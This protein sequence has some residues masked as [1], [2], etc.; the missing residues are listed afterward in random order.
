MQ[1]N[2][3]KDYDLKER[4]PVLYNKA[5]IYI[6]TALLSTFFGAIFYSMNLHQF[7]KK[8]Q[9]PP[10]LIFGV[11]WNGLCIYI[12]RALK[13]TNST[14]VLFLPNL[15]GGLILISFTWD[16]HFKEAGTFKS[17]SPVIPLLSVVFIWGT[18]Y[19]LNKYQV[20]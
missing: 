15:L 16:Y 5:T 12:L 14:L 17:R 18:I 6:T 13:I 1:S 20:I 2:R 8:K 9:I 19:A 11:C 3:Y 10:M 7:N 4:P